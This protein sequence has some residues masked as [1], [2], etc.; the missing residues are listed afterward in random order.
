MSITGPGSIT[1]ANARRAEQSVQPAQQAEPAARHRPGFADL[2]RAR[3]AGRRCRVA[4]APSFRRSTATATTRHGA[5]HHAHARAIGADPDRQPGLRSSSRSISR[6]HLPSTKR[7]RPRRRKPPRELSRSDPVAAQYPGRQQ[8]HVFGQRVDRAR[9]SPAPSDILN[10]NGAQAGLVQVIAQRQQAD[11]GANG[12]GRL[13]VPAAA[14]RPC[15]SA[16][17]RRLAV[18]L[19]ACGRQFGPDRRDRDRSNRLAAVD[20]GRARLQ[21]ELR[22]SDRV[23]PHNARRLEPDHHAAGNQRLAAGRRPI[24]NRR[25]RRRQPRPICRRR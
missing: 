10:G 9:R 11:Q 21:S 23:Q 6:R 22:R 7:A 15:R 5:R 12:L 17:I 20:F 14:D 4:R 13:V 24:H 16:R 2:C 25:D 8:L 18:R 1:A 3:F 19:Q